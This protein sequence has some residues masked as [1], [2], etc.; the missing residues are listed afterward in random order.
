[1]LTVQA[2]DKHTCNLHENLFLAANPVKTESKMRHKRKDGMKQNHPVQTAQTKH[3]VLV[4]L[5]V[6]IT[7]IIARGTI[8]TSN[9][10]KPTEHLS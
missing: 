10:S 3:I 2:S 1:M 6:H 9:S 4:I 7:S 5:Y 8:L